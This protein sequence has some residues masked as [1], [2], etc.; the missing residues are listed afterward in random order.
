MALCSYAI[1]LIQR[2]HE[3][4]VVGTP[5][6]ARL[7]IEKAGVHP[8]WVASLQESVVADFSPDIRVGTIVH[9]DKCLWLDHIGAMWLARVPI[10]FYWGHVGS[11]F[12]WDWVKYGSYNHYRPTPAE[13]QARQHPFRKEQSQEE[14]KNQEEKD[15]EENAPKPNRYSRQKQG[16]TWQAFFSRHAEIRARKIATETELERQKRL[17]RERHAEKHQAPSRRKGGPTIFHWTEEGQFRI[18]TRVPRAQVEDIWDCY[19]NTQHRF[20]SVNNEWDICT[21]FDPSGSP[22]MEDDFVAGNDFNGNEDDALA[23]LPR[24]ETPLGPPAYPPHSPNVPLGDI[25]PNY[26][27]D[28]LLNFYGS[29]SCN[30]SSL[31][32]S[33]LDDNLF[34]WYGFDYTDTSFDNIQPDTNKW[35]EVRKI[36]VDRD[37]QVTSVL[38]APIIEFVMQLLAQPQPPSLSGSIWDLSDSSPSSL[39]FHA[40][41]NI[42]VNPM[43]FNVGLLYSIEPVGHHQPSDEPWVLLVGSAAAA[44]QCLRQSWGPSRR[45]VAR[46]LVERGIPFH[47]RLA[48]EFPTHLYKP[49]P[50]IGL[51]WRAQ[52]YRP[53]AADYAA[54][55]MARNAFL[56]FSHARAALLRGGIL[57]RLAM[58]ALEPN[59]AVQ[60]PSDHIIDHGLVIL[61][62]NGVQYW[63]D[64]L[65]ED[66]CDLICGVYKVYTSMFI[67]QVN[68]NDIL[69]FGQVKFISLQTSHGGQN[70]R[71]GRS[72]A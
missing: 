33:P 34:F 64:N 9:M 40:N 4:E 38:R 48:L 60:G 44:V 12:P 27:C 13:I 36:L 17:D 7:L 24:V 70:T 55:E 71:Y 53:D 51:G 54:Y 63:D 31:N 46:F 19:S 57:W 47:T 67:L 28:D 30:E 39:R 8:E 15:Q 61:S 16:E 10:W 37:A 18:R 20:D 14:E 43:D 59:D 11:L 68:L 2:G 1:S 22:E 23:S 69:T 29:E 5:H 42:I 49:S 65:S 26:W 3:E 62:S 41:P 66:E 72:R 52:N 6:W 35:E 21:E 58:E 45:E 32:V 25:P 50:Y 56:R